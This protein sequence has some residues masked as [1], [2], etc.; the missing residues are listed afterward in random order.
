MTNELRFLGGI[1]ERARLG[2]SARRLAEH[3][4]VPKPLNE[5]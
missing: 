3:F 5:D 2:R 1:G 4:F